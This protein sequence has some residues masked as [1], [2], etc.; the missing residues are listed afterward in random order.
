MLVVPDEAASRRAFSGISRL[1][2]PC[3]PAPLHTHLTSPSSALKTSISR[4]S[5]LPLRGTGFESRMGS[6]DIHTSETWRTLPITGAKHVYTEVDVAFQDKIGA[7]HVYTEV[8]FAIGSQF[9]IRDLGD[10]D[11]IA[12]LQG[13]N[14]EVLRDDLRYDHVR[15]VV[16][17]SEPIADLHENKHKITCYL[18][19]NATMNVCYQTVHELHLSLRSIKSPAPTSAV[20]STASYLTCID[21]P[22]NTICSTLPYKD[23]QIW[24][25]LNNEVLRTDEGETIRKC[26]GEVNG[27][28]QRK[29]ADQR[30]SPA[31]YPRAKCR[32]DLAGNRTRFAVVGSAH[33]SH[34][35]TAAPRGDLAGNRTRFA[36][37][38]SAHPSHYGT[39]APRGDLA[40]NRTRFAVVG[41]AHPSHYGTAAPTCEISALLE[42][43]SSIVYKVIIFREKF[44][45]EI[46]W[47][48]WRHFSGIRRDVEP[49]FRRSVLAAVGRGEDGWLPGVVKSLAM[50]SLLA[51]QIMGKEDSGRDGY[52]SG[53]VLALLPGLVHKQRRLFTSG[54]ALFE[55]ATPS[56]ATCDSLRADEDA[57]GLVRSSTVMRGR[58]NRISPR[59]PTD[60]WHRPAQF[61]HA[62]IREREKERER[63]HSFAQPGENIASRNS[64]ALALGIETIT[65]S[66]LSDVRP[67]ADANSRSRQRDDVTDLQDVGAPFLNQLM[68][69]TC[70]PDGNTARRESSGERST[71]P[72]IIASTITDTLRM[73]DTY[74]RCCTFQGEPQSPVGTFESSL[75][76][77]G[78]GELCAPVTHLSRIPYPS[79]TPS[80]HPLPL[81]RPRD[82]NISHSYEEARLQ[83]V[84][85]LD[86]GSPPIL[87]DI[88]RGRSEVRR[89]QHRNAKSGKREILGKTTR[90]A[91]SS[92]TIPTCEYPGATPLGIEHRLATL[93]R[94]P[95]CCVRLD[96]G[97]AVVG[98]FVLWMLVGWCAAIFSE[99]FFCSRRRCRFGIFIPRR[100]GCDVTV[101][102]PFHDFAR[103]MDFRIMALSSFED[104]AAVFNHVQGLSRLPRDLHQGFWTLY[105]FCLC[106]H[107]V[108]T[109]RGTKV[110]LSG[111]DDKQYIKADGISTLPWGHYRIPTF[112][113]YPLTIV[114]APKLIQPTHENHNCHHHTTLNYVQLPQPHVPP[115]PQPST[116]LYTAAHNKPRIDYTKACQLNSTGGRGGAVVGLLASHQGEPGSIH[117]GE[118]CRT[119]PLVDGFSR[120]VFHIPRP[121]IPALLQTHLS[122]PASALETS[123][124]RAAQIS[125]LT[126]FNSVIRSFITTFHST[127]HRLVGWRPVI[128][129][130]RYYVV[131]GVLRNN[132]RVMSGNAG[133]NRTGLHAVVGIS[134]DTRILRSREPMRAK[135]DVYGAERERIGPGGGGED[136]AGKL[137]ENPSTSGQSVL[138]CENIANRNRFAK[139]VARLAGRCAGEW[140]M[141]GIAT[142]PKDNTRLFPLT[143]PTYR[144][145]LGSREVCCT[146]SSPTSSLPRPKHHFF[147]FPP[148][149]L[150][151]VYEDWPLVVPLKACLAYS[152]AIPT[153]VLT[154]KYPFHYALPIHTTI[155]ASPALNLVTLV[156]GNSPKCLVL[157][158]CVNSIAPWRS[159]LRPATSMTCRR[160]RAY[161]RSAVTYLSYGGQS[162]FP[163]DTALRKSFQLEPEIFI[164]YFEGNSSFKAVAYVEIFFRLRVRTAGGRS[165]KGDTATCVKRPIASTRASL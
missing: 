45:A 122:S 3:I 57:A 100:R 145:D 85:C 5:S 33:P 143:R 128:N 47:Y 160:H 144:L 28:P 63:E 8:Y 151:H 127:S 31:R 165:D 158:Q 133:T 132:R 154:G 137:R 88:P 29:P 69:E 86:E 24:T 17:D 120:W 67:T 99:Q 157:A 10:S 108:Y 21:F 162:A 163:P 146:V 68:L 95:S 73:S 23:G 72:K 12:D 125:S 142:S 81:V 91:A 40:G 22:L 119:M 75:R 43:P 80:S 13:N 71:W 52:R 60:Q 48:T 98:K 39:A 55:S 78:D 106:A 9:S 164:N 16:D 15:H 139:V 14:I 2:R 138:T 27:R 70:S 155:L 36:V 19:R 159:R 102:V 82:P 136:G 149:H 20:F 126:Q 150:Q 11:P 83:A 130:A 123:M 90:P 53:S 147:F 111:M 79:S 107:E 134:R 54:A 121:C 118:S 94:D 96:V 42:L 51:N 113:Y 50:T 41:S 74:D 77:I 131:Y 76:P 35:T 4:T 141:S 97:S 64:R 101:F 62:K 156:T 140:S 93:G 30:H 1:P 66:F 109:E 37:V 59:K 135:R 65:L 32:G 161:P 6:A 7:K 44:S 38:G 34:Y 153:C 61:P 56:P 49:G 87:G 110:V 117:G 124:S 115:V 104:F 103:L 26:N 25:A 105:Q 116:Q 129:V 84:M 148:R 89:E 92:G 114:T 58:G 152:C 112:F 46:C 18:S